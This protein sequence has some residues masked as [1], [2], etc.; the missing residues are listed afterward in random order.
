MYK[1]EYNGPHLQIDA[2]NPKFAADIECKIWDRCVSYYGYTSLKFEHDV[3]TSGLKQAKHN[4]KV[5]HVSSTKQSTR[6][7]RAEKRENRLKAQKE[8]KE[9]KHKEID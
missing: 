2:K 6:L 1:I 5:K 9:Q 4:N 8:R 3:Y 7:S